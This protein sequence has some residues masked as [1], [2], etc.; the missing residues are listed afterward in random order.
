[1]KWASLALVMLLSS[2]SSA[3]ALACTAGLWSDDDVGKTS[4]SPLLQSPDKGAIAWAIV[5]RDVNPARVSSTLL[6]RERQSGV[7]RV[8]GAT[9][10]KEDTATG[11]DP[12]LSARGDNFHLLCPIDWSPD[13][14][15]LLIEE[16]IA[17]LYSDAGGTSYW[18]YD[19]GPGSL[20]QVDLSAVEKA[21]RTYWKIT[22]DYFGPVLS[23]KGWHESKGG[24]L[25]LIVYAESEPGDRKFLGVWRIGVD[26]L[27]P[28][29]LTKDSSQYRVRE[30]GTRLP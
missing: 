24:K 16:T 14:R 4:R 9:R 23:I 12:S 3:W 7:E 1:M 5:S 15:Q 10:W 30:F 25:S 28:H 18:I 20:R 27:Q 2:S 19:R 11:L 29:L 21:V 6:L 22:D 17:P 8:L 26:G 13:G